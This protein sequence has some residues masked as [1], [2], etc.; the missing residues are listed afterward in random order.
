LPLRGPL[1]PST[2]S[3][4]AQG[5]DSE[6]FAFYGK[7]FN[8]ED[9]KFRTRRVSTKFVFFSFSCFRDYVFF[10]SPPLADLGYELIP[11][12]CKIQIISASSGL[13]PIS[14]ARNATPAA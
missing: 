8:H 3:K 11:E 5:I 7:F 9:T 1:L 12:S 4:E 14:N 2:V 13:Q 10:G 6:Y